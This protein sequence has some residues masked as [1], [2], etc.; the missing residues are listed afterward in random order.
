VGCFTGAIAMF[1]WPFIARFVK[2]MAL[3]KTYRLRWP[4]ERRKERPGLAQMVPHIR[5]YI[6]FDQFKDKNII[7]FCFVLFNATLDTLFI[8]SVTGTILYDHLGSDPPPPFAWK[9]DNSHNLLRPLDSY[10][11]E[12]EQRI[13]P[14]AANDLSN[15]LFEQ[16]KVVTFRFERVI[17]TLTFKRTGERAQARLWQGAACTIPNAPIAI[18]PVVSITAGAHIELNRLDIGR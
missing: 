12:I 11:I 16:R 13:S 18:G 4:I 7:G 2:R 15:D 6:Y 8:E 14:R 3:L 10:N 5:T 1:G 9:H 17:I